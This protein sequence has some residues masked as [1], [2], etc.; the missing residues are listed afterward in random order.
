MLKYVTVYQQKM[1]HLSLNIVLQLKHRSKRN[2]ILQKKHGKH[3]SSTVDIGFTETSPVF[4]NEH[5]CSQLKRL[6][7]MTVSP[8]KQAG[9]KHAWCR[10]G[11]IFAKK[12]DNSNKVRI[13]NEQ[14]LA[15]I[16]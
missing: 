6:M 15:K 4:V 8:K 10:D 1:S 3:G 2:S 16:A 5:L 9:W 11:K 14:D 13:V 12:E 7:G